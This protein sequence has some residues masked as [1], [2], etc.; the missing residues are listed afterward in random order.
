MKKVLMSFLFLN[1]CGTLWAQHNSTMMDFKHPKIG[2]QMTIPMFY[3]LDGSGLRQDSKYY[4]DSLVPKLILIDS[5]TFSIESH[6]DCRGNQ[7]YNRDLSKR[8]ADQVLDYIQQIAAKPLSMTAYGIGEDSLLN[9]CSC[10]GSVKQASTRYYYDEDPIDSV[11]I[12]PDDTASS[13]TD[14]PPAYREKTVFYLPC[15]ETEHQK[16]RRTV[17]RI[18]GIR[19]N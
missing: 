3:D 14:S 4:L 5:F 11:T 10:E 7:D 19:E 9:D 13:A 16:N 12:K 2:Q 17:L 1:I 18:T 8:R 6:T 15:N